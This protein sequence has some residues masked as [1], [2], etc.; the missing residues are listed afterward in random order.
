MLADSV[1]LQRPMRMRHVVKL[2]H[3]GEVQRL[4]WV[5]FERL[6]GGFEDQ[7][8]PPIRIRQRDSLSR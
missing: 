7:S 2:L 3:G 6:G 5:C 4:A 8:E 1:R